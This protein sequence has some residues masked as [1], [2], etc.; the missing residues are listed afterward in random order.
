MSIRARFALKARTLIRRFPNPRLCFRPQNVR[1]FSPGMDT[2][3]IRSEDWGEICQRI[4]KLSN[5]SLI[6][7]EVLRP[8]GSKDQVGRDV[9]FES[10]KLDRID[11]CSDRII[12]EWRAAGKPFSHLTV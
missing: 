8:D 6:T 5:G 9:L 10:M 7:I 12:V 2:K 3:E 11:P 1:R 4:G